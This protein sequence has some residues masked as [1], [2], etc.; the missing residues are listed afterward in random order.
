MDHQEDFSMPSRA[1]YIKLARESCTR[2]LN[3]PSLNSKNN[4]KMKDENKDLR[5]NFLK[6]KD[7]SDYYDFSQGEFDIPNSTMRIFIIRAICAFMLFL[8]V[9][10]IDKLKIE[11]K[12]ISSNTIKESVSS[13][14]GME[15]AENFFV[16]LFDKEKVNENEE[17]KENSEY[18]EDNKSNK[19]R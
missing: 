9:F 3:A 13:N 6:K 5:F 1:E 2:N 17:N 19:E 11:F 15:D 7:T 18:N 12:G 8:T 14:Q 16:S 4:N 10:V